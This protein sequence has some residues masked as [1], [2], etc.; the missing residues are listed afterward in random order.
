VPVAEVTETEGEASPGAAA[1][2]L[3]IVIGVKLVT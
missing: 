3:S 2:A 1:I